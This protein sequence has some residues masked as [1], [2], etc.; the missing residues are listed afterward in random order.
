MSNDYTR[1]AEAPAL[2]HPGYPVCDAC[3]VETELDD[4][5]W[6][7]PAC[8]TIW[9]GDGMEASGDDATLYPDWSGEDLT[10]PV[11]PNHEAWRVAVLPPDERDAWIRE[12]CPRED[13][14]R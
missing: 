10:G 14:T 2:N 11:C 6:M 1:L 5:Q 8:G 13:P 7:C 3:D 4:S 9:P 12:H